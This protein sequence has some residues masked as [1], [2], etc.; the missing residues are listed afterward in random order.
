MFS[1]LRRQLNSPFVQHCR[2]ITQEATR[3]SS[4]ASSVPPS[5]STR[6]Y[7]VPRNTRSNLPVYS[8]IRNGGT[9]QLVLIRNVE[10]DI[11]VRLVWRLFRL[12]SRFMM[13]SASETRKRAVPVFVSYRFIWSTQDEASNQSF[14]THRYFWGKLEKWGHGM[15]QKEGLL[16]DMI[17]IHFI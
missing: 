14:K 15:A 12:P 8:D 16:D 1:V 7:F 13:I 4:I 5:R 17:C 2:S 9:R 11:S 6:S 3:S 10:G